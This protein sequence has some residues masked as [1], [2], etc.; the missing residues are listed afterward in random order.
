ME[1]TQETCT[2]ARCHCY[3]I[4][5]PPHSPETIWCGKCGHWCPPDSEACMRWC[6]YHDGASN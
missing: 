4:G 5:S 3:E 6:P 2:N 1:D